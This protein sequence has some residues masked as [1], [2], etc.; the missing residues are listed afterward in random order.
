LSKA[1]NRR[2]TAGPKRTTSA[3]PARRKRFAANKRGFAKRV[4]DE[5]I[6]KGEQPS[7]GN[8]PE[9][10]SEFAKRGADHPIARRRRAE[11]A[12]ADT[13]R[14]VANQ[15][16]RQAAADRR[17]AAERS[18]RQQA[19]LAAAELSRRQAEIAAAER[20]RRQAELAAAEAERQAAADRHTAAERSR[21]QQAELAAA[22]AERV[23]R[24]HDA[25][26][27]ER[28]RKS[29]AAP[30]PQFDA[31]LAFARANA[32]EE[33]AKWRVSSTSPIDSARRR[34]EREEAE[35]AQRVKAARGSVMPAVKLDK[36]GRRRKAQGW[37]GW[38]LLLFVASL[39]SIANAPHGYPPQIAV[40]G[41]FAGLLGL[42]ACGLCLLPV[43]PGGR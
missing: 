15:A 20:S 40:V 1:R 30:P 36:T 17:T 35:L 14:Q 16:E 41:F 26:E 12:Q 19:E 4:D 43:E 2:C 42:I 7:K 18:R 21:R 37:V 23:R 8:R 39:I 10:E 5:W 32:V 31:E 29:Y 28:L 22:E 24:R 27:A 38:F 6:V 3:S 13:A 25:E 34:A 11:K 9:R 33:A